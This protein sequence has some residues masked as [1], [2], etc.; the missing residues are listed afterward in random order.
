MDSDIEHRRYSMQD[1]ISPMESPIENIYYSNEISLLSSALF[2][3]SF[4]ECRA[5]R[6]WVHER[7]SSGTWDHE[8]LYELPSG[9]TCA[10]F[11]KRQNSHSDIVEK[12]K[13][14]PSLVSYQGMFSLFHSYTL[15]I[16]SPRFL[17]PFAD[18][19]LISADLKLNVF[20]KRRKSR[21]PDYGYVSKLFIWRH[22]RVRSVMAHGCRRNGY[23][24][25][26]G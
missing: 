18:V 15:S 20:R 21:P 8:I 23:G 6:V 22:G 17:L 14:K 13:K 9:S 16:R 11:I 3:D 26:H 2:C 19:G 7:L 12:R 5:S 24:G 10:Q 4:C 25:G 1:I